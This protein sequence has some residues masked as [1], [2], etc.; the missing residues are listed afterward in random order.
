MA[1]ATFHE[2]FNH[3]RRPK[4]AIA[5]EVKPGTKNMPRDVVDAAIAAGKATAV[6]PPGKP[7]ETTTRTDTAA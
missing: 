2:T 6:K 1:W 4:Q 3:D 5:F 7:S